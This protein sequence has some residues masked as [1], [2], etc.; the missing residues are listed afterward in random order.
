MRGLKEKIELPPT[1][2]ATP[3]D[4]RAMMDA[5]PQALMAVDAGGCVLF[6][7]YAAQEFTGLGAPFLFGRSLPELLGAA[8]PLAEVLS[9]G[10][11]ATLRDLSLA[12][13]SVNSMTVAPLAGGQFLV[14]IDF[15]AV[16]VKTA[17]VER[18]KSSLKPAQ[19]IARMLAHEIKNPLAGIRGAAQLLA[20]SALAPDDR[21]LAV[22]ID[23]ET[24]RIGRLVE[25]VNIFEDAPESQYTLVNLNEAMEQ[26]AK[27]AQSGF[28]AGMTVTR[29]YDPS[30]PPIHGHYDRLVQALLNLVKNAAEAGGTEITL[31][32][33]YDTAAGYHPENR[34][35]LPLC[36]GVEDNGGGIDPAIQ[37]HLFEPYRST[38]PKGEGLGL[39][40]V[41]KIIDD[42]GGTVEVASAPGHTVFKLS[43]PRG[44]KS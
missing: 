19:H 28:A 15:D 3:P 17:W 20:S 22:L 43:F 36:L 25:R 8:S 40:L 24:Q 30:L 2:P 14:S 44:D 41:S 31:R 7:N 6:S 16:P 18:V 11:P 13:K 12:G 27:I 4:L 34:A 5:L 9:S 23:T 42:H 29:L 1:E 32:S 37:A 39:S 38:K 26:V 10:L 33:W 35:R 21:E